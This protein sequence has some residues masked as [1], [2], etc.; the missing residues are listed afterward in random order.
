MFT[1]FPYKIFYK[2][3][4]APESSVPVQAGFAVSSR[5]FSKAVDRN[6]IKRLGREA[7]RLQK[8]ELY[9]LLEKNDLHIHLFLLY[10]G[11]EIPVYKDVFAK[12]Q[13]IVARLENELAR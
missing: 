7:W 2:I 1:I 6:R 10:T 3:V 8:Q 9:Q 5:S 12:L 11:R 13:L 4:E